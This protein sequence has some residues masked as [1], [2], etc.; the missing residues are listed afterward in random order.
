VGAIADTTFTLPTAFSS[1]AY[2]VT[3]AAITSTATVSLAAYEQIATG[4][5][6]RRPTRLRARG[7]HRGHAAGGWA[8]Q[9][10]SFCLL[11]FGRG[12][13]RSK[14]ATWIDAGVTG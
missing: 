9:V 1:A 4:F 7:A 11:A 8:A 2:T 13:R 10:P 5:T 14:H 3:L 12:Q 6:I